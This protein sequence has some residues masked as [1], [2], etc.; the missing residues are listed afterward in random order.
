MY[1]ASF[2]R[3][4]SLNRDFYY[5][6]LSQLLDRATLCEMSQSLTF[7]QIQNMALWHGSIILCLI[8]I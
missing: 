4:S 6:S 7:Y 2:K 3:M 8:F 1:N 5:L